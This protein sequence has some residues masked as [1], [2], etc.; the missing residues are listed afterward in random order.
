MSGW[1]IFAPNMITLNAFLS[2]TES[3]HLAIKRSRNRLNIRF[4]IFTSVNRSYETFCNYFRHFL[5]ATF[6]YF[7]LNPFL[8]CNPNLLIQQTYTTT[9][10]YPGRKLSTK[11]QIN[12]IENNK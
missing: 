12:V 7:V 4:R 11:Q 5:I 8:E 10:A 6:Q 2:Q 1:A 9:N 3:S